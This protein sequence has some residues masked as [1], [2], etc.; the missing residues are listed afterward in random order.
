MRL[1]V[2]VPFPPDRHARHGGR[3]IAQLL[4]R[5]VGRHEIGVV[6]LSEGPPREADVA[7]PEGL[8]FADAIPHTH[9][10]AWRR[11]LR[12]LA[13]PV[14]GIPSPV[15]ALYNDRLSNALVRRAR[16]FRPHVVQVEHDEL[17]YCGTALRRDAIQAPLLLIC[18]EPGIVAAADQARVTSG[19]Q[20]VAHRLDLYAWRLYLSRH[21]SEFDAVVALTR[22]DA[23]KI[24]PFAGGARLE[25]IGLGVDIPAEPLS[26][27]GDGTPSVLFVG[28]YRH[29]PNVDAAHRLLSSIMPRVRNE[30]PEAR[31][32]LVG[33]DPTPDMRAAGGP[34]DTITGAVPYVEPFLNSA[35][36]VALPIRTGGGM[37]VKLLEALAA[38]KAV[39]A[40]R[41]AAAGLDVE[42]GRELVLA[43]TDEEF[44]EALNGLLADAS[45]R[46]NL[47]HAAREWSFRALS[48]DARV[49]QYEQLYA[50][51]KSAPE[52]ARPRGAT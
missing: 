31:L 11:R 6:Y 39:V 27:T 51:L 7:L 17:S 13:G 5:L 1:L 2:A 34:L 21:L 47:G 43:E 50:S 3:V 46:E 19:R 26:H 44:A 33:A 37:R 20:R 23:E 18:H 41:V 25:A 28:G 36:I 24:R 30:H 29:P 45:A 48:W 4:G 10:S 16:E 15:A 40:S 42:S 32:L 52:P 12:V 9:G 35:A 8:A 14:R 38:G 22:E 49:A